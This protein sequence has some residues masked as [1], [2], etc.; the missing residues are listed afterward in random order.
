[1]EA[2]R[3]TLPHMAKSRWRKLALIIAAIQAMREN[4]SAK[5]SISAPASSSLKS[6]GNPTAILSD[7][8]LGVNPNSSFSP[9]MMPL[10]S[11]WRIL[12]HVIVATLRFQAALGRHLDSELSSSSSTFLSLETDEAYSLHEASASGVSQGNSPFSFDDLFQFPSPSPIDDLVQSPAWMTQERD[13]PFGFSPS[14][15]RWRVLKHVVVATLRLQSIGRGG[16][17]S[18][19]RWM[20]TSDATVRLGRDR[21]PPSRW[22]NKMN[23][24][25]L[26]QVVTSFPNLPDFDLKSII[27]TDDISGKVYRV[28]HRQTGQS[29]ALKEFPD[30]SSQRQQ[31][32][33]EVQILKELDHPNLVKCYDVVFGDAG[34]SFLLLEPLDCGSSNITSESDLASFAYQ[35]LL[36]LN[37]LHRNRIWHGDIKP[38]N[39]F[40]DQSGQVKLLYVGKTL[41]RKPAISAEIGAIHDGFS[42]DIWSVGLCILKLGKYLKWSDRDFGF[43]EDLSLSGEKQQIWSAMDVEFN[44][45]LWKP[46][47]ELLKLLSACMQTD[48]LKR[49]TAEQLV[50]H[51]FFDQLPLK[52]EVQLPPIKKEVQTSRLMKE[53]FQLSSK[54]RTGKEDTFSFYSE[55]MEPTSPVKKKP[56]ISIKDDPKDSTSGVPHEVPE[57]CIEHCKL[58]L[59]DCEF[60]KDKLVWMWIA[61]ECFELGATKRMED[62]GNLYFD[63]LVQR[64]VIVASKFDSILRQMMYKFNASQVSEGVLKQGKYLRIS[65]SNMNEIYSEALHLTW[66]CKRLD[67]TFSDALKNFKQLHTLVVHGDRCAVTG[68]LPSDFFLGLKLLRTLDLSRTH[69]AEVPGS[70]GKLESLRYLDFSGTPIQRLPES[71]DRLH[72]LQTLNLKYCVGLSALPRGLGK[73]VDLRHVDLDIVS[74]LKSMPRGMGNLVKLQTLRAFIVGRKHDGCGIG[75]LRNMNEITGPFCISRL[76]NVSD[77]EEAK[78]AALSDKIYMEK[79]ELRWN[80]SADDDTA[81]ILE[82]LQPHFHLKEVVLSFYGGSR[83][84]RWISNP[85]YT[86]LVSMT[87]HKC[88]NCDILPSIGELP[89]LKIL[90]IFHMENVRNI[91][92]LFCRNDDS[93]VVN[94]FPRLEQLSVEGMPVLEEWS[95]VKGGDFPCLCDL[96]IRYCPELRLLPSLSHL[97]S[98]DRLEISHCKQL[99]SLTEGSLPASLESLI[100][101]CCPGINERCRKDGVDWPKIAS[102][103]NIWID[104]EKLSLD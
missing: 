12:K 33:G 90:K 28:V 103:R 10:K 21:S 49:W 94:A 37:F 41:S 48:V 31:I 30:D 82:S 87:L 97:S 2:Y 86:D 62:V 79:L 55:R 100:I 8:F 3:I 14:L 38:S 19:S 101:R 23:A 78:E 59:P 35:L 16:R 68:Q 25:T 63:A 67:R 27:Q 9:S 58:F 32:S 15:S 102:V 89:S 53:D 56:K 50:H 51:P 54:V 6:R 13:P 66:K 45:P 92:M 64:E 93:K 65:P 77:A 18:P 1:M 44:E 88:I 95:G 69:V 29:Y 83:L 75:E 61:E 46:S 74:Q 24:H 17:R 40:V 76:E 91:D 85:S 80:N 104:L 71:V 47:M 70:I 22:I 84:P 98:L 7:Y 60:E 34:V 43:S 4:S 52:K 73:L 26:L 36:G 72:R 42:W 81:E 99:I 5:K 96:S 57:R 20:K 11:R 39:I